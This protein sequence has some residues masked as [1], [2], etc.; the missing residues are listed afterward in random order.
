MSKFWESLINAKRENNPWEHYLFG[1]ALTEAQIKEISTNRAM[2]LTESY[3]DYVAPHTLEICYDMKTSTYSD[4]YDLSV[5]KRHA[6]VKDC[7]KEP[8]DQ[9]SEFIEIEVPRNIY[10]D[11]EI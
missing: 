11:I 8:I 10:K 5:K 9:S 6:E 3:G 7:N 2:G 4:L 1:Q